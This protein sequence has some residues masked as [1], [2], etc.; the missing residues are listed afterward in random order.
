MKNASK[1]IWILLALMLSIGLIIGCKG[2]VD[3]SKQPDNKPDLSNVTMGKYTVWYDIS[4][5][6]SDDVQILA[7]GSSTN[8]SVSIEKIVLNTA[9]SGNNSL[10]IV[11][12][13]ANPFVPPK[14]DY[15]W[16]GTW[17]TPSGG[18]LTVSS[19]DGSEQWGPG[20]SPKTFQDFTYIGFSLN[21]NILTEGAISALGNAR[22]EFTKAGTKTTVYFKDLVNEQLEPDVDTTPCCDQNC[23]NCKCGGDCEC[24]YKGP[25]FYM[26]WAD[27]T[28]LTGD[29]TLAI[30]GNDGK[31]VGTGA[32]VIDKIYTNSTATMANATLILDFTQ[33]T[34]DISGF[35]WINLREGKNDQLFVSISDGAYAAVCTGTWRH[36][37]ITGGHNSID[38]SNYVGFSIWIDEDMSM[39]LGTTRFW[40]GSNA[41]NALYFADEV[42]GFVPSTSTVVWIEA[43]GGNG[44]TDDEIKILIGGDAP[45]NVPGKLAIKTIYGNTEASLN[46]ART[47][48][49]FADAEKGMDLAGSP[50]FWWGA[51]IDHADIEI[52]DGVITAVNDGTWQLEIMNGG[53]ELWFENSRYIGF[54]LVLEDQAAIEALGSA[55]VVHDGTPILFADLVA[56]LGK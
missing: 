35:R 28:S 25:G 3:N 8:G 17:Q 40:V 36:D 48:L 14:A 42:D 4:G 51:I 38:S 7:G 19:G 49:D 34:V 23:V 37:V 53:I 31:E 47:L 43:T 44:I 21:F 6:S 5:A 12:Y 52:A 15:F 18:K 46:G 1:M 56:E 27:V 39:A 33:A 50:N 32:I 11:D 29:F 41:A 22:F 20:F 9:K 2:E 10:L 45:Y 24:G 13:T 30:G 54:S 16:W 26:V 55:R